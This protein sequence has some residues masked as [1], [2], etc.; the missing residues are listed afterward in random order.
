MRGHGFFWLSSSSMLLRLGFS[1][2]LIFQMLGVPNRA[3][4]AIPAAFQLLTIQKARLG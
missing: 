1:I 2:S 3:V 4:Y